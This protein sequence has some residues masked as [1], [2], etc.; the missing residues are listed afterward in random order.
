MSFECTVLLACLL[1]FVF[2]IDAHTV[3][4]P[5]FCFFRSG[6]ETRVDTFTRTFCWGSVKF[7][8][9]SSAKR[10]T[11]SQRH[12]LPSIPSVTHL[13]I[14][15][16]I[17]SRSFRAFPPWIN[18]TL[19]SSS[20]NNKVSGDLAECRPCDRGDQPCQDS[21]RRRVV[22]CFLRIPLRRLRTMLHS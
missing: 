10:F 18:C 2:R 5:F 4:F 11:A 17:S 22:P 6:V 8:K 13:S 1:A 9:R 14:L 3:S 21:H 7:A 19:N 12:R 15:W 20:N 16:P